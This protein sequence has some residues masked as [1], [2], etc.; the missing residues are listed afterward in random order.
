MRRC[1]LKLTN[2]FCLLI[3]KRRIKYDYL[4]K[5]QQCPVIALVGNDAAWT[6][7]AREQ[8]PMFGSAVGTELS[9]TGK[10]H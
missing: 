4:L 9:F 7:I 6:Q 2:I 3:A 5:Y 1:I 10:F 8:V